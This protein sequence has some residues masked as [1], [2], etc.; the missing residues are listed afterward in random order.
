MSLVRMTVRMSANTP[1]KRDIVQKALDTRIR[2]V[3]KNCIMVSSRSCKQKWMEIKVL[4][5]LLTEL[6]AED[7]SAENEK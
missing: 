5:K 1:S 3:Q 6:E 4:H 7:T 2:Y